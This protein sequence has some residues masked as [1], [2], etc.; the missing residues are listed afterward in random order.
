MGGGLLLAFAAATVGQ[1]ALA[2]FSPLL[3]CC[4]AGEIAV[5]TIDTHCFTA[6]YDGQHVRDRH[7]VKVGGKT[8]YAGETLYSVEGRDVGFTYWNSTGGIGRGKVAG[9]TDGLLRFTGT[10]RGSPAAE[11][12]SFDTRWRIAA[13]QL[14]VTNGDR[15]PVAFRPVSAAQP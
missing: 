12:I 9:G 2:P 11:P 3:G 7:E 4:W 14:I 6:V 15:P 10:M 5:G 1:P 8:V 13:D